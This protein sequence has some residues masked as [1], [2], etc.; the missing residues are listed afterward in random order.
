MAVPVVF[1]AS[2]QGVPV[3]MLAAVAVAVIVG[4]VVRNSELNDSVRWTAT[5]TVTWSVCAPES[6]G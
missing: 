3:E 4:A 2:A 5:V 1:S 6:A